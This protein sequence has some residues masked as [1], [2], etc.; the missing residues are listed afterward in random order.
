MSEALAVVLPDG[1]A[2]LACA[3]PALVRLRSAGFVLHV[4]APAWSGG[5]LA[6]SGDRVLV[7]SAGR[8][9][10]VAAL[11]A[12]GARRG[13]LFDDRWAAALLLHRAGIA[14]VGHGGWRRWWVARVLPR[15]RGAHPVETCWALAGA[16]CAD[17][18]IVPSTCTVPIPGPAQAGLPPEYAVLVSTPGWPGRRLLVRLLAERL[19]VIGLGRCKP[20]A[21]LQ[22][23]NVE[24][25]AAY[26][27]VMAGAR[28]VIGADAGLLQLAA[29]AGASVVSVSGPGHP[30]EPR[31]WTRRVCPLGDAHGWPSVDA[32]AAAA[33]A[34]AA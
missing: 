11:R 24:G 2:E 3:L 21:G 6:A 32:V 26:L 10:T 4:L 29:L 23:L 19:A 20:Q 31:P 14:A 7:R 34:E 8:G 30:V 33:L 16:W 27:S 1:V 5:L 18:P 25:A 28:V 17:R 13:V 15:D 22:L 9:A 12:S